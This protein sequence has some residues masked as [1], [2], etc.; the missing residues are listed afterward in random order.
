MGYVLRVVRCVLCG[1]RFELRVACCVFVVCALCVLCGVRFVLFVFAL[2]VRFALYVDC[3]VLCGVCCAFG[4]CVVWGMLC[5]FVAFIA[6]LPPIV[7][8]L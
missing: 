7:L 5:F 8:V 2:C 1:V 6:S 4:L 3:C